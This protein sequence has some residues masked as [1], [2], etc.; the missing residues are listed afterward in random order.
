MEDGT[1]NKAYC[2]VYITCTMGSVGGINWG[3]LQADRRFHVCRGGGDGGKPCRP[4]RR[5]GGGEGT[6][7][8]VYISY[9]RLWRKEGRLD[10]AREGKTGGRGCRKSFREVR[11]VNLLG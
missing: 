4:G 9:R 3:S 6:L 7:A 2:F 1:W 11:K 5:R 10:Q 8:R